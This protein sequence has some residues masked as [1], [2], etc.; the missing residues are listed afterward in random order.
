VS[1]SGLGSISGWALAW[2]QVRNRRLRSLLL[3]DLPGAWLLTFL[4]CTIY[5][6]LFFFNVAWFLPL[7]LLPRG[8]LAELLARRLPGIRA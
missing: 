6:P 1:A 8:V 4:A 3:G 2:W 5:V 7:A